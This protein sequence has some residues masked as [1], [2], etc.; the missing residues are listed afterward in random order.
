[1]K[2]KKQADAVFDEARLLAQH[3]AALTIVQG[4][5][6]DPGLSEF[7]WLDLACGRGQIIAQ[8]EK[9]LTATARSKI[10]YH[11]Y[12]RE[13][14]YLKV[15]RKKAESLDL[16][17]AVFEIGEL[18]N[19]HKAYSEEIGFNFITLT[20]T[21]HE[22]SPHNLALILY[23][24]ILRLSE[25]GSLFIY[26]METL[27]TP[28]MGAIPWQKYEVSEIITALLAG[29]DVQSYEPAV[30][31]WTHRTCNGWNLQLQ[32][33]YINRSREAIKKNKNQAVESTRNKIVEIIR[34]KYDECTRALESLTLN[35]SET[36]REDAAEIKLL[37]DH[38][39]L[40]RAI[41]VI[42]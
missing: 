37:Y 40:R 29:L 5:L 16:K 34:R 4:I 21:V 35:Q 12:D 13:N 36:N 30:G 10:I 11:G 22:I 6:D 28:E 1:M 20:N 27:P 19:F 26:D 14:S 31:Q 9:N 41:E 2:G 42:K 24:S 8:L 7:K 33:R 15:A 25:D 32:R 18:H 38:W 3:Q 39:A 17:D 23:E